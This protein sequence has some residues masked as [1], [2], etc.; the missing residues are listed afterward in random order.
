MHK[1]KYLIATAALVFVTSGAQAQD[2]K[3]TDPQIA[4]IAYTAGEIDIKAAELALK[5]TQNPDVK[6]FAEDML[7]DHKSVNDQALALCKKLGVTPEDNDTSKSLVKQA[8]E[9]RAKLEKLDGAAFD[10]AYAENEV[11]Y[12]HTVNTTLENTLIPGASN[13]ELKDFL[14]TGLKIFKGHEEHAKSLASELK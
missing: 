12:H 13:K 14:A 3:L 9:E 7:R 8:D 1:F 10:R 6:A 2:A 11:S 4:H 5:K